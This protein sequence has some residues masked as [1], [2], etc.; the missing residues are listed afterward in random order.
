[1]H[2]DLYVSDPEKVEGVDF[3]LEL[4]SADKPDSEERNWRK[5]LSFFTG[6]EV[7]QGWNHVELPLSS[8]T[9]DKGLR[10]DEWDFMRVHNA[11]EFEA[12]ED[13]FTLGFKNIY[14]TAK[15]STD[16]AVAS[17]QEL[18]AMLAVLDKIEVGDITA[19]N[20]E[21][22]KADCESA[23]AAYRTVSDAIKRTIDKMYDIDKIERVVTGAIEAYE[24]TLPEAGADGETEDTPAEDT[25]DIPDTDASEPPPVAPDTITPDDGTDYTMYQIVAIALLAV[26]V[27][28]V[29]IEV[30][31]KKTQ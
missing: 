28:I 20:Y 29:V 14:F 13:G 18:H 1:M 21:S 15:G 4:T 12:G 3:W 17:I 24:Q 30:K 16:E 11:G 8:F 6:G 9:E 26:G 10:L 7:Q 31:T 25:A 5:P 19:E 22:I 27:V 23:M 2:F